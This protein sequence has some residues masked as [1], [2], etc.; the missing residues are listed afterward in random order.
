VGRKILK[1]QPSDNSGS[2]KV[3]E[4][5]V[6]AHSAAKGRLE[7][8]TFDEDGA[9]WVTGV[10]E[11]L[12]HASASILDVI[13]RW[14]ESDKGSDALMGLTWALGN[15]AFQ[16]GNVEA[17]EV[18]LAVSAA[19]DPRHKNLFKELLRLSRHAFK[20]TGEV[21]RPDD[22]AMSID[23]LQA[24][25]SFV[26]IE[27]NNKAQLGRA[28]VKTYQTQQSR[29]DAP[30]PAG[31]DEGTRRLI[32]AF[33]SVAYRSQR[34]VDVLQIGQTRL[35]ILK[36]VSKEELARRVCSVFREGFPSDSAK[37]AVAILQAAGMLYKEADNIVNAA[38]AM[39]QKRDSTRSREPKV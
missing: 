9:S 4:F 21:S 16:T 27:I 36:G 18:L 12:N 28:L 31:I 10:G 34:L 14:H 37:A 32:E 25:G 26:N 23:Y 7:L 30:N 33:N 6:I 20:K 39:K 8:V 24:F 11:E 22:H 19:L 13:R 35:G 5:D 38:D 3:A 29:A 15:A 17:A 2:S 1:A